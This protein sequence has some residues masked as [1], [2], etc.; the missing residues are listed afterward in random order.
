[1]T[2]LISFFVAAIVFGLAHVVLGDPQDGF[3]RNSKPIFRFS[4]AAI[5]FAVTAVILSRS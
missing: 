3:L 1:M 5:A 4:A 2:L